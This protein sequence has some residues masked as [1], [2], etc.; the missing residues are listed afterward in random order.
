MNK[1]IDFIIENKGKLALLFSH[2]SIIAGWF[3]H[4][5]WPRIKAAYPYLRDNGGVLGVM[6]DFMIGSPKP[7]EQPAKPTP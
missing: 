3:M 7:P 2:L 5:Q 1:L 4:V 6:R